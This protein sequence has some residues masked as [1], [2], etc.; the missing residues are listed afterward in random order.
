MTARRASALTGAAAVVLFLCGLLFGDLLGSSNYPPLNASATR[1]RA[2][3][4]ANGGDVRVLALAHTLS[5]L[6]LLAFGACLYRRLR[7][8]EP[9]GAHAPAALAGTLAAAVFLMLSALCYRTLVEHA[10]LADAGLA[11]ALV[12]LSYLAGGPGISVALA[13]PAIAGLRLG[14]GRA[15]RALSVAAAIFCVAA[16]VSLAGPMNNS[17]YAY[18]ILLAAAV[19]GFAWVFCVSVW[20][21]R[22][23]G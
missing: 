20:L 8:R 14:A 15:L 4:S 2:Y 23:S 1:V 6:C 9:A 16:A 17:S 13:L 21:A 12:M 19:F 3:F 18:G 7:E 10:V 5:A 11:H 22:Q